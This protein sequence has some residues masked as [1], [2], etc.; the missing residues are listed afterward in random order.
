MNLEQVQQLQKTHASNI[1]NMSQT[2]QW[3]LTDITELK[4][5]PVYVPQ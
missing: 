3:I 5:R 4:N 1:V 2:L